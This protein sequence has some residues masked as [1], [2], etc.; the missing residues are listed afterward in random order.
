[1]P[2]FLHHRLCLKR[3]ITKVKALDGA[4]MVW[5][6]STP[7]TKPQEGMPM[8]DWPVLEAVE[9]DQY[10][11]AALEIVSAEGLPVNDLHQTVLDNG[12]AKCL[13]ED[14]CHMQ[15]FGNEVLS[16]AVAAAVR[17]LL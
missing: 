11:A 16:D 1:M 6:T 13:R 10:N 2:S 3:F 15:P 7:R 9:L 12:C 8:S 14:G 17:Q 5:A 4:R